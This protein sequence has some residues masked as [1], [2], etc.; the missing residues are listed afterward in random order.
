MAKKLWLN[1]RESITIPDAISLDL[2]EVATRER[3]M[4]FGMGNPLPNPDP[5]LKAA[6]VD[7]VVYKEL[8]TDAHVAAVVGSRKAGVKSMQ[9]EVE[10][11]D[12]DSR[13]FNFIQEL[14]QSLNIARIVSRSLDASLL[15]YQPFE[16]IWKRVGSLAIPADVV[17]KPS[18]WFCFSDQNELRFRTRTAWEGE[19]LPP[20]KMLLA[21]HEATYENPYGFPLLSLVYWWVTI[22]K[23]GI[24]FWVRYAEKY[25]MPF[26]VGKVPSGRNEDVRRKLLAGMKKMVQDVA[27]VINDDESLELLEAAGKSSSTDT[28]ERLCQF[29]DTQIS[30]AI[31]GQTLTTE[32]G[33]TGGANAAA[34]THDEV[35]SEIVDG[36]KAIAEDLLNTLIRWVCDVNFPMQ[37][38]AY[39]TFKLFRPEDLE[40]KAKRDKG[41][42][43]LGVRYNEEYFQD[44]YNLDKKHFTIPPPAPVGSAPALGA[45][46]PAGASPAPVRTPGASEFADAAPRTALSPN[47]LHLHFA[48]S[49]GGA[50]RDQAALDEAVDA[51]P[52]EDLQAMTEKLMEPIWPILEK[53]GSRD[54]VMDAL[55]LAFSEMKDEDIRRQLTHFFFGSEAWG[56]L[57][58]QK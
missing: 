49:S 46:R 48:A 43:D 15:G 56:H 29:C 26:A 37:G 57:N 30:K 36:D 13:S 5:I 39:P 8:L 20:R 16:V 42:Y 44:E 18:H 6:G 12:A 3:S 31:V 47:A 23:G 53:G 55:T 34:Q 54:Q 40:S 9:W 10:Q 2:G 24:K 45:P 11:G 33:K 14:F 41:I 27:A 21:R 19:A 28:Y 50:Y 7:Q 1:E 58:A 32:I 51:L 22:K 4:D 38:G 17:E 25:G 52:A 35:R